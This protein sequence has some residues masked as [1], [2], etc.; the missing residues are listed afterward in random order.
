M[1][2]HRT[3]GHQADAG[4][5]GNGLQLLQTQRVVQPLQQ[6]HRQPALRAKQASSPISMVASSFFIDS[7]CIRRQKRADNNFAVGQQRKIGFTQCHAVTAFFNCV[8]GL[9]GGGDELAQIAPA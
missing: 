2:Q 6:F 5:E 8:T 7:I 1:H 9:A 3:G 4:A